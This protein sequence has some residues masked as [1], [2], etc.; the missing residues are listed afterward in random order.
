[1]MQNVQR[2]SQP[3]CTCTKARARPS[4]P[5]TRCAA[6][7]F[8]T[9]MSS[10]AT[11]SSASSDGCSRA[12]RHA[13]QAPTLIF[14]SLPST[15]ATSGIAAKSSGVVCAAQPVT[16]MR[17]CGRSRLS[18]RMAWRDCRTASAVTAQVLTTMTSD[19]S[20]AAAW[21]PITSAS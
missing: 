10:T 4:R 18:L 14:S 13:R 8:T 11:F 3:F 2:W 1:M 9:M 15:S 5:S 16:T 20:A 7:S 12:A 19:S 21:R 6:V 17:A